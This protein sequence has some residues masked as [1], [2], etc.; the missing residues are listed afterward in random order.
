MQKTVSQT[1]FP[2]IIFADGASSG[3]PGPGGWGA[4]IATPTGQVTELGGGD[5][6]TTNNRM[7]LLATLKALTQIRGYSGKVVV[8]TDSVYVIR[9]ITQWIWG[10]RK[11][12]WKTAEG[13]EVVNQDLW[14]A[15][16]GELAQQKEKVKVDWKHVRGHSGV[17]GN[18]RVDEIAVSF[19]KGRPTRLYSGLL[20]SYT[21]PIH[22]IPED[23]GLPEMKPRAA[24]KAA[25]HSYVSVVGTVAMRH[26]DWKSCESRVKG[27][28]GARFKRA[29]TPQEEAE[30]L[31]SWGFKPD[32]KPNG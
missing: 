9:G 8:Y 21:V 23:N 16:S 28:S 22:D 6:Q 30:I 25:A 14:K 18:E 31:R 3:N 29:E 4:I 13:Q 27:Q 7:E 1:T 12:G 20:T 26:P 24:K 19:S 2:L 11:N 15:L 10:W 5:P 32:L 17:P